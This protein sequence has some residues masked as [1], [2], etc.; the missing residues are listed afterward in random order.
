MEASE[1][2]KQY[3][4]KIQADV[5]STFDI[6]KIARKKNKDPVSNV[7]IS[8]ASNM[9]E[10][11]VG[12]VS[13]IAPQIIDTKIVDRIIE[14]EKQYGALDWRVAMVISLEVAQEKFCKF[15]DQI[16]AIEV[17]IRIGF[18][19][20]TV[21]VVSSPLEGF[22][23]LEL[24]ERR[25]GKGKFFC[26]NFSGPIRN[27][28]GTA[29]ATCVMIADYVRVNMGFVEYDPDEKEIARCHTEV[30]DYHERVTNLQY[31][32][33]RE[34]SDFMVT[35]C[36]IEISGDPTEKFEV[37]NYKDLPRVPTNKI[38][39]GFCLLHSSCLPLKAEKLNKKIQAW[40]KEMGMEHW[41]FLEDFIKIKKSVHATDTGK[42][43]KKEETETKDIYA[44][45]GIIPNNTFIADLVAGRPVFAYPMRDGGFRLRYGRS[46]TSGFS[47][48]S[49]NPAAMHVVLDFIATGTQCKM[50]R[51][52]KAAAL[53]PCD[54]IEGPTVLLE[55]G[56]V[57]QLNT[58]AEGREFKKQVKKILFLGDILQNYGDY[59]NR[60]HKLAKPGYCEEWWIQ[61]F[62]ESA[63][64]KFGIADK[65]KIASLLDMDS[66][67]IKT[68]FDDFLY[69]R[70]TIEESL[71]ISEKFKI[72]LHPKYTQHY[73]LSSKEDLLYFLEILRKAKYE[74]EDFSLEKIVIEN[75]E[76]FKLI[77]ENIGLP[78][79]LVQNEFI[80]IEHDE[81]TAITKLLGC[82][83][84][85]DIPKI[86]E[87][88]TPLEGNFLE[89]LEQ[90]SYIKIRDKS[91]VFVGSRMGRPEKAKMRK[92]QG[93][94]HMLFPVGEEGGRLRSFQAAI[95]K[96][97][98]TAQSAIY[99]C[100]SCGK[101]VSTQEC[102]Y[103]GGLA[104]QKNFCP[105]CNKLVDGE[106][107]QHQG[108][109]KSTQIVK[110]PINDY[111]KFYSV[112]IKDL[113]I[114][115]LIK[116]VRGTTNEGS[117]Y[118][119]FFKGILRAKHDIYVNKDGTIRY[120]CSEVPV[121][122]FKPKEIQASVKKLREIGYLKDIHGKDLVDDN[123]ILEIKPQDLIIPACPDSPD[124][125]ADD[126]L[127]RVCN[128]IDEMLVKL[129]EQEPFYNLK[130]KEDLIGHLV[131]ALAPH[132]S[133]GS[134]CRII[135]FSK[136]QTFLSHPYMHAAMRRDC[137]GDEGCFFLL[138]D[139]FL[140]F[141]KKYLPSSRG[142]TM[143][144]PL[145]LT[146]IVNPSEVDDMAF[147]MDIVWKYP[148]EFYNACC[149]F[150]NPWDIKLKKIGDVLGTSDQF[151]NMG[152]THDTT[153]FNDGILC[154]SYKTLPSMKE[155]LDNQMLVAEKLRAV[156]E[157]D[158]A[159]LVID[160]HFLK[161][162]KGNLRKFSQQE[163]RCI[164]CN[165][166]YRRP[167]LSQKCK[168]CGSTRLVF[169]I[170]QGSV[171][172]YLE[173]SL[174]LMKK[175]HLPPYICQTL[176]LLKDRVDSVFGKDPDKQVSLN[177]FFA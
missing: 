71:T 58:D 115:D 77:L 27:A 142:S 120:D 118:E 171:I 30:V 170:A 113:V 116:G 68:L 39:S 41:S 164:N 33:S 82:F 69:Q 169:T 87:K 105:V 92:M 16:E 46:R 15:K 144:A 101:Q 11:V 166:K 24:K 111:I 131:V 43:T 38:R 51:P 100:E 135:G 86:I 172:K 141:S 8:L 85:K 79:K 34:E 163:L 167:P 151:E 127:F 80:V 107:E 64:E 157:S 49:I 76:K 70:P 155:K 104:K 99:I 103:C 98:I 32:P 1:E 109:E 53:S 154:S 148:L 44:K 17:G 72:P 132:T 97:F 152:F 47:A 149:D 106:C 96:G 20:Q 159:R 158:V 137:D 173:P 112:K 12:L 128:Y 153:D 177:Q 5:R 65:I 146:S 119:N 168:V 7:E 74:T 59:L 91:G 63:T 21:G 25:D 10:R 145:V 125:R 48:Q 124:E 89:I 140:N 66:D 90:I 161:D 129:Y 95:E 176:E 55:N 22:T 19:Y 4:A 147:D 42:E 133:S 117:Y 130:T 36:P 28:G 143:D 110:I 62:E 40:G 18:A 67:R 23:N 50:E 13:T 94:P 156:D 150:K 175:Y 9:A 138:M 134:V 26:L 165:T 60:A 35:K 139:A 29:A 31:F 78:H 121:T 45:N 37:S 61:E 14:L 75:D 162:I 88:V 126:V 174:E 73:R 108:Q 102:I 114:P 136:T 2:M 57:V 160:K 83:E 56:D 81:A 123:Q 3:F 54:T 93:S 6:A 84:Q 52:G 122:H